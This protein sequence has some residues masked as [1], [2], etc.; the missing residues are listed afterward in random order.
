MTNYIGNS[1]F[2]A[3]EESVKNT[4]QIKTIDRLRE[5]AKRLELKKEYT[6]SELQD[7]GVKFGIEWGQFQP[8]HYCHNSNCLADANQIDVLREYSPAFFLKIKRGIYKFVGE[9]YK[10]N[11]EIKVIQD[12]LMKTLVG[13]SAY[14][15]QTTDILK[16]GGKMNIKEEIINLA[17][18]KFLFRQESNGN[19]FKIVNYNGSEINSDKINENDIFNRNDAFKI[20]LI[21][22]SKY[23]NDTI[24]ISLLEKLINSNKIINTLKECS[25][26]IKD[27]VGSANGEKSCYILSVYKKLMNIEE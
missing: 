9:D 10:Y 16:K 14:H 2:K 7:M 12:K 3:Q 11:G 24:R 8:S 27:E 18:S 13:L 15:F 17:K 6:T 5:M 4:P 25:E 1:L 20:E 19:K 26:V 22:N 21:N 23:K